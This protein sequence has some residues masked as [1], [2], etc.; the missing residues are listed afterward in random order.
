MM[1]SSNTMARHDDVWVFIEQRDG[2]PERVSLE[3]LGAGRRLAD[4]INVDV[5]A[6]LIGEDVSAL[7]SELIFWGAD[8]VLV[9]DDPI[10]GEYRTEVYTRIIADQALRSRPE[11]LLV[12]ATP[13]GRDLAPRIAARLSTGCTADCTE[14]DIDKDTGVLVATKPYFGR[15]L[16][17]DIICPCQRPQMATVRPGVMELQDRD[18]DRKGELI[19][20]DVDLREEDTMVTVLDSIRSISEGVPLEESEK[21][22]AA[23]MGVGSR[24]GFELIRELAELL[25]AQLGATSLPVDE[26]WISE[27]YKIGQTGQTIRPKLYIGCGVS[28]AIQHSAGMINSD[29]IVAINTNPKAEIFHFADYGIIGDVN[30]IVPALIRQLKIEREGVG[31]EA[32]R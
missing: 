11:V 15:N 14:L 23:G 16:M 29:L 20:I 4:T 31:Y 12:G 32:A 30:E 28:G 3:L 9:A 24:A 19:H 25:G 21:V 2:N 22:V 7:A 17:A 18:G 1:A 26:G 6:I 8:T 27:D 10:A 13:I 5:T